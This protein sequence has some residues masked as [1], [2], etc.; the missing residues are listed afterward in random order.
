VSLLLLVWRDDLAGWTSGLIL[1]A[2]ALNLRVPNTSW[3]ARHLSAG[4]GISHL[5]LVNNESVNRR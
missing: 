4:S 2:L 5:T 3:I 1:I